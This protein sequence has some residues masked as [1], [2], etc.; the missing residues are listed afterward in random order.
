MSTNKDCC[1]ECMKEVMQLLSIKQFARPP[2]Y[3]MC[4]GLTDK[5]NGNMKSMLKRLCSK[6]PR[7]LHHFINLLLFAYEVP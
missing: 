1:I 5:F 3:P 4:C 2:Y 6:Q 7:Q